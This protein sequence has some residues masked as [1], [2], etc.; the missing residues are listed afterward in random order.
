MST[1]QNE[2]CTIKIQTGHKL[3]RKHHRLAKKAK[4]NKRR[5]NNRQTSFFDA[6]GKV[7]P[8]MG[9]KRVAQLDWQRKQEKMVEALCAFFCSLAKL[10]TPTKKAA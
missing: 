8:N 2:D 4:G 1:C 3:C 5:G 6:S 7:R 9:L 10:Q